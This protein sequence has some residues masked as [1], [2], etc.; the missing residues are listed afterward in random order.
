MNPEDHR[1]DLIFEPYS[2][3]EALYAEPGI[4]IRHAESGMEVATSSLPERALGKDEVQVVPRHES[5]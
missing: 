2:N 5:E 4:E 3:L 1:Q